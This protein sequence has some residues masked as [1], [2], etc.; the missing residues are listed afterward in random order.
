[1]VTMKRSLSMITARRIEVFG[2]N[3]EYVATIMSDEENDGIR[4]ESFRFAVVENDKGAVIVKFR[5]SLT[6]VGE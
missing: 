5:N 2:N 1:M 3:G 6:I 4:I